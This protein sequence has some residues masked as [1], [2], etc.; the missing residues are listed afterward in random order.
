MQVGF[1][2]R[3]KRLDDE[4]YIFVY[5]VSQHAGNAR[6]KDI[7]CAIGVNIKDHTDIRKIPDHFW[8]HW[9]KVN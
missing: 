5:E 4:H 7:I 6:Q 2:Y 8:Q 9:D 3:F 1:I